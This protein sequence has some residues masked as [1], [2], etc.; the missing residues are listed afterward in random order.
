MCILAASRVASVTPAVT[1][2]A[3]ASLFAFM[4]PQTCWVLVQEEVAAPRV[5]A[6]GGFV[7]LIANPAGILAPGLTSWFLQYGRGHRSAFGFAA[8]LAGTGGPS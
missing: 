7:H 3:V 4:T 6:T 5:S 2:S 8:G 1:L